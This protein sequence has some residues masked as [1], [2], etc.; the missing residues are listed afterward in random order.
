MALKL[1]PRRLPRFR[2]LMV[3]LVLASISAPA[4]LSADLF[5]VGPSLSTLI[6]GGTFLGVDTAHDPENNVYL[7]VTGYGQLLAGVFTDASGNPI[8]GSRFTVQSGTDA[9]FPRAAYSPHIHGGQGG[10]LVVWIENGSGLIYGRLVSFEVPGH[11]VNSPVPLSEASDG[12]A[13]SFSRPAL[14]YSPQSGRFLVTWMTGGFALRA[15]FVSSTGFMQNLLALENTGARDPSVT[16]NPTTDEFG[17]ANSSFAGG[18]PHLEF[19]RIRASDGAVMKSGL[20]GYSPGTYATGVDVNNSGGYVVTWGLGASTQSATFD[21]FGSLL[22]ETFV[23]SR[24]GGNLSMGLAYSGASGTGLVVGQDNYSFEVVGRELASGG[25]PISSDTVL[26]V[27]Q[28]PSYYPLV[29]AHKTLP[30]WNV[31]RSLNFAGANN[32]IISSNGAS[33]PPP[34]AP[35]PTAPP[36]TSGGCSTPDPFTSIGGGTCVNGGW[37]P[38]GSAP[39]P[40]PPPTAPTPTAPTGCS[41]P[42]PFVSIGG[43]TCVNGGWV[44]GQV[45]P[46]PPTPPPT[47][48]PPSSGCST[49]DPFAS[50]GGGTCVNGGWIPGGSGS[51]CSTPDPFASIGGGT[52]ANGGWIPGGGGGGSSSSGGTGCSTPDP[53]VSI[54]GGSCVNGGWT[55]ANASCS[56]PDPFVSLGGGVCINGGWTPR[57]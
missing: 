53:F 24:F 52:C 10:F 7:V 18:A 35:P 19:R 31:V 8:P 32:Q 42:D 5:R 25:A 11:V 28:T 48:P 47:T 17:L 43:G 56:T 50:I 15:R 3:A 38:S 44:P 36:P 55:P 33:T 16:W 14:A 37:V 54:G 23:S 51:G 30:Q 1:P 45:A 9:T 40:P 12:G 26:T 41:T 34:T 39:P 2:I 6:P 29:A 13:F 49:P 46:P 21:R 4:R 27:D 57:G 22:A 20:F